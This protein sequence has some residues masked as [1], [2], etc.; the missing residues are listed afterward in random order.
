ML[1]LLEPR[2]LLELTR[3]LEPSRLLGPRAATPP[4]AAPRLLEP[5]HF[6]EALSDSPGAFQDLRCPT[7]GLKWVPSLDSCVVG[8]S[9]LRSL[10]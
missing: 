2:R 7:G 10:R 8:E 3:L 4:T 9:A 5:R 6:P 1:C